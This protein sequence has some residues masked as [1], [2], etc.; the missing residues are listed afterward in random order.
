MSFATLE[1]RTNA[2]VMRRLSN[3]RAR[4]VGD[5]ADFPV[6]FERAHAE[7]AGVSTTVPTA[8]AA[9]SDLAGFV[10]QTTQV[11]IVGALTYTVIDMRPDGTGL[12]LLVLEA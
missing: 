8:T 6:I 5:S 1:Q 7:L 4:R 12:T 3:A 9:D 2:V 10:A 11:E